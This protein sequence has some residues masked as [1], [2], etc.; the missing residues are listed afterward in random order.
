MASWAS[1]EKPKCPYRA[2]CPRSRTAPWPPWRVGS[3][4]PWPLLIGATCMRG[5]AA[6][7]VRR[8]RW[9]VGSV[10]STGILE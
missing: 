2:A 5:G 4:T 1:R 3:I 10:M 6:Q 7:V 8:L 9:F